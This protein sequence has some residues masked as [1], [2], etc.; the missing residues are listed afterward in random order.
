M[1]AHAGPRPAPQRAHP[2]NE[3]GKRIQPNKREGSRQGASRKEKAWETGAS[4]RSH[5][6]AGCPRPKAAARRMRS[7]SGTSRC[8][9]AALI[10]RTAPAGW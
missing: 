8:A 9:G 2:Q 1:I 5:Q 3:H 4:D 7:T 10:A 6:P